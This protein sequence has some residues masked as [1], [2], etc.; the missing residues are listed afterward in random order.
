LTTTL[1]EVQRLSAAAAIKAERERDKVQ[2]VQDYQA[3][4]LAR[5][6][7]NMAQLRARRLAKERAETLATAQ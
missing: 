5:Q 4:Q 3:E 7:T 2:G 6:R 1:K